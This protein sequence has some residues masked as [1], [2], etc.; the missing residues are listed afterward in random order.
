MKIKSFKKQK[1]LIYNLYFTDKA[2]RIRLQCSPSE[3]CDKNLA[4]NPWTVL[5]HVVLLKDSFE[6]GFKSVNFFLNSH[7]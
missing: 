5:I 1:P 6:F 7:F 4:I 3:K 2:L